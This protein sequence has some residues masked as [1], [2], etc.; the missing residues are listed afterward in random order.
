MFPA[1]FISSNSPGSPSVQTPFQDMIYQNWAQQCLTSH[2]E[3]WLCAHHCH[4][5]FFYN[6]IK[7]AASFRCWLINS[8]VFTLLCW[9][10]PGFP[11]QRVLIYTCS[12]Y[13]VFCDITHSPIEMRSFTET[14]IQFWPGSAIFTNEF[15]QSCKK[16]P[17][18][19]VPI[20]LNHPDTYGFQ[21]A[22]EAAK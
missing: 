8:D 3:A 6:H 11:L 21:F 7:L 16:W 15:W 2:P 19:L 5:Q 18:S 1:L 4:T 13:L 14:I 9:R 12:I 10:V 20:Y 17:A 22:S